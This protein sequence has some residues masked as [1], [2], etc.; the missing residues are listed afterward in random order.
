MLQLFASP[1]GRALLTSDNRPRG[2]TSTSSLSRESSSR[3]KS[4]R[5]SSGTVSA[6]TSP[7]RRRKSSA[8][9]YKEAVEI[10]GLTCSLTD[11]CRCI[12]CQVIIHETQPIIPL[13]LSTFHII[14]ETIE[15][16]KRELLIIIYEFTQNGTAVLLQCLL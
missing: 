2:S 14:V 4:G 9:L 6:P 3:L 5:R 15:E 10:L 12:D 8:E 16:M 11:S 13:I 1:A 7:P